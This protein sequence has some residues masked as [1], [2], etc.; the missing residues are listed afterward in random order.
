MR[1]DNMV[2]VGLI[3]ALIGSFIFISMSGKGLFIG[4]DGLNL[5]HNYILNSDFSHWIHFTMAAGITDE[6]INIV[7]EG[8]LTQDRHFHRITFAVDT[9]PGAGKECNVTLTD[10][11]GTMSVSLTGDETSGWTETG[12]FD[13]DVS[14]TILT[15]SYTQDAGGLARKGFI[16][17][18]YHYEATP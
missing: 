5:D 15:L 8:I 4:P 14:E 2:A 10:G 13:W 6:S 17:I 9:A 3:L 12:E 1:R 18:K 7:P 11:V 16:T